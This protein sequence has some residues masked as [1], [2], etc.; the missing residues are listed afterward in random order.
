MKKPVG[1]LFCRDQNSCLRHPFRDKDV[2]ITLQTD[3]GRFHGS[4]TVIIDFLHA[5]ALVPIFL[6]FLYRRLEGSGL[7]FDVLGFLAVVARAHIVRFS[8]VPRVA[9]SA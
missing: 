1:G 6:S 3:C 2:W 4:R 8:S 7:D 9:H 5:I